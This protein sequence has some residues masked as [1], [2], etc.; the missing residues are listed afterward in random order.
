MTIVD[1]SVWIDYFN[2]VSTKETETLDDILG[3]QEIL[4][5][6]LILT[7]V[8]QGFQQDSHFEIAQKVLNAFPVVAMLGPSLAL[9]SAQHYRTLRKRGVT[10]RKTIDVMIGTF[11]IVQDVPLLYSDRDFTPM[12]RYLGLRSVL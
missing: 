4:L 9:K 12:V 6:D 8:L 3:N 11:C 1:T 2:D 10:V 7:E 5:G